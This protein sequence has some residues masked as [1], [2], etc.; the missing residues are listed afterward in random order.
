M[1]KK[2]ANSESHFNRSLNSSLRRKQFQSIELENAKMLK[3]LQEKKS[4]YELG[5]MKKD[6]K[7]TKKRIQSITNYPIVIE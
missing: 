5:K 6:W 3:R 2:R 1:N 4:D 7:R